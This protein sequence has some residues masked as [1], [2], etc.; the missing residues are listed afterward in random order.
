[1]CAVRMRVL[2]LHKTKGEDHLS[3]MTVLFFS[4]AFI[5]HKACDAWCVSKVTSFLMRHW[6]GGSDSHGLARGSR[7]HDSSLNIL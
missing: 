5:Y 3:Y 7:Y 6:A 4:C 2:T 1:M